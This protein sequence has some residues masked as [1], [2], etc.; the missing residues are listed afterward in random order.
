MPPLVR[1]IR[2]IAGES[3]IYRCVPEEEVSAVAIPRRFP[4]A[5][6][7]L[8]WS[9]PSLEWRSP[10]TCWRPEGVWAESS[11]PASRRRRC[12]WPVGWREARP[13]VPAVASVAEWAQRH[14]SSCGPAR[15]HCPMPCV[16]P[17]VSRRLA[18]EP[19][20]RPLENHRGVTANPAIR[21]RS[22]HGL[23]WAGWSCDRCWPD[24]GGRQAATSRPPF[25]QERHRH[26]PVPASGRPRLALVLRM[27]SVLPGERLATTSDFADG[28]CCRGANYSV[29]WAAHRAARRC[30]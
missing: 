7:C 10:T 4:T 5:R 29:P 14:R 6:G 2:P 3:R 25:E 17:P 27:R 19:Q 21:P 15:P 22:Q 23:P 16:R 8:T 12:P 9:E 11:G 18:A 24:F 26:G 20:R 1:E 30:G 28:W 13:V